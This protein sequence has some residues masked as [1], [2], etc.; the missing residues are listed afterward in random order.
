MSA[1]PSKRRRTDEE[2]AEVVPSIPLSNSQADTVPPGGDAGGVGIPDGVELVEPVLD[3][4]SQ[5]VMTIV[6][7]DGVDAVS[8]AMSELYDLMASDRPGNDGKKARKDATRM[9]APTAILGAMKKWQMEE[10]IQKIGCRCI[11]RLTHTSDDT[12]AMYINRIGG[13]EAVVNAMKLF[14]DKDKVNT[15][16]T[17]AIYNIIWSDSVRD[18]ISHRLV[19]DAGLLVLVIDTMAHFP[20]DENIQENCCGILALL[21]LDTNLREA[22]EESGAVEAVARGLRSEWE[23]VK[24]EA[25]G[26]MQ[27][28]Y[29]K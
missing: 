16:A 5:L 3:E 6:Q 13:V 10:E 20:E 8:E 11:V 18:T 14:P 29:G 9:G 21:A 17:A 12:T 15:V 1:A 23:N 7:Q 24:E 28:M 19:E 27:N 26:F 2:S 4:I 22:I 25:K